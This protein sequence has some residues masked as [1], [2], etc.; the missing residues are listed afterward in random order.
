[1]MNKDREKKNEVRTPNLEGLFLIT[2]EVC[3][4]QC[5]NSYIEDFAHG[6]NPYSL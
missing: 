1:M 3:E 2:G 6:M 4:P 5:G